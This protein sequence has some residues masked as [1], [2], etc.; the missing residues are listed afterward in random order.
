[1]SQQPTGS[2]QEWQ[3]RRDALL[4]KEKEL[5]HALEALLAERRRLTALLHKVRSGTRRP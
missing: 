3:A 1:M 4:I 5:T 2:A